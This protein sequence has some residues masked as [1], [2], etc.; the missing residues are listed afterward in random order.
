MNLPSYIKKEQFIIIET[1]EM[2]KSYL[3]T[4]L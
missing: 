2:L 3:K 1:I 4:Y